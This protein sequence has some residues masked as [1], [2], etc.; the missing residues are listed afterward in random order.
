MPL[1]EKSRKEL[2]GGDGGELKSS[3]GQPAKIQALHS[4]SALG[5]NLFDYWRESPDLSLLFSACG[6]S[7]AHSQLSGEIK[8]EQKFPIDDRFQYSPN[9]DVVFFHSQPNKFK[10]FAIECKF[11]EAYSSRRHGGLDQ[12][13]FTNESAWENL[14]SIKRL[15]KNISPTDTQFSFLNAAQLIKHILGLNRQFGH[16]RYRLLYLWYDALGECGYRHRKE[17]EEFADKA[18]ADGVLFHAITY[19]ELIIRL[20]QF[21]GQHNNYISYLTDR[22]L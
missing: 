7:R 20:A 22:Y 18:S 9:L 14:L 17:V 13:Y 1:K 5:I 2:E 21:R 4:S 16:S 12:K 8:F 19:Q 11:T 15:A 6:L 10:V 3:A